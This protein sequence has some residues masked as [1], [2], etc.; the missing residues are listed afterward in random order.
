MTLGTISGF[1]TVIGS[2]GADRFIDGAGNQTYRP[3]G[4]QNAISPGFGGPEPGDVRDT[5]VFAPGHGDDWIIGFDV[6]GPVYDRIDLRAF[7]TAMDTFREVRA[8]ARDEPG[9]G[10][11][12]DTPDGGSITLLYV[13]KS[14]LLGSMFLF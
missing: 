8:A 5:F 14:E 4:N 6:T 13:A 2:A 3:S 12:I 1:E 7:G 9:L 11:V 10:C